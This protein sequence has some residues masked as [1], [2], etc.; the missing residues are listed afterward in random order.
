MLCI[1]SH[2]TAW[3]LQL[4]CFI[5]VPL[6]TGEHTLCATHSDLNYMLGNNA[7]HIYTF[8]MFW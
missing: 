3:E 1:D 8:C 6:P 7:L 5:R 2:A 4:L